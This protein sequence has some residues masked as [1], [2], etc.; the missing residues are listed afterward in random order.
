MVSLCIV[1]LLFWKAES[2]RVSQLGHSTPSHL[3]CWSLSGG[4]ETLVILRTGSTEIKDRF[5]VHAKTTLRCYP[6][7][8]VFSDLEEEFAGEHIID[9]LESVSPEIKAKHDDFALYRRLKQH[10]RAAFDPSELSGS[11]SKVANPTGEQSNPGWKL[12]KWKFLPM[13]NRTIYEYP[14]M[15]WYVFVE[16][17]TYILWSMLLRYLATLDPSK[18]YYGGDELSVGDDKFAHG[19]TGFIVSRPAL[20]AVVA[21]YATHK[22][23]VEALVDGHGAGDCVLGKV[24]LDAGVPMTDM[25][26]IMQGNHPGL[27]PYGIP[28]DYSVPE[29]PWMV[30][31]SPTVSYHHMSVSD[32]GR[33]WQFEQRWIADRLPVS[34][35]SRVLG[36]AV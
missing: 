14:H 22:T 24:F 13:M 25:F 12:D 34:S 35:C 23:E 30:W 17:D 31:C 15:K 1:C 18:P 11:D 4:N 6:H 28:N 36:F 8:L 26:P 7:C 32:V 20:R 19:G 33:L 29:E 21:F 5:P 27:V 3:P 9:A 2:L 10:G 16:A